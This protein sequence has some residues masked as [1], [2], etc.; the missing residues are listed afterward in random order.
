MKITYTLVLIFFYSLAN[1]QGYG[2]GG[3]TFKAPKT[4]ATNQ[5]QEENTIKASKKVSIKK[6]EQ[7][8]STF[9]KYILINHEPYGDGIT[10]RYDNKDWRIISWHESIG[11]LYKYST[12]KL[13]ILG[14]EYLGVTV[15]DDRHRTTTYRSC[16]SGIVLSVTEWYLEQKVS[17]S[18]QW[19]SPEVRRAIG[20]LRFCK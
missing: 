10:S 16:K 17:L 20:Y 13:D 11:K 7:T 6:E 14:Y 19:Y 12:E 15:N 2:E 4:V 8:I 3:S 9:E 18:M 1:G 5:N